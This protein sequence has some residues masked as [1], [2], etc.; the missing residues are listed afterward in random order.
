MG[1]PV[2]GWTLSSKDS[3]RR[4]TDE[5]RRGVWIAADVSRILRMLAQ[6]PSQGC[7]AR[8][9]N[10]LCRNDVGGG[11]LRAFLQPFKHRPCEVELVRSGAA[12]AMLHTRRLEVLDEFVRC[13]LAPR[14]LHDVVVVIR[15]VVRKRPAKSES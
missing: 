12:S 7:R 15:C 11:G 3:S 14:L 10:L 6:W 13:G 8:R 2:C 1:E 4:S 5:T 9:N